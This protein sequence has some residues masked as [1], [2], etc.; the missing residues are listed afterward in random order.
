MS[1]DTSHSAWVYKTEAGLVQ[2]SPNSIVWPLLGSICFTRLK[3]PLCLTE[4]TENLIS[5]CKTLESWWNHRWNLMPDMI[6]LQHLWCRGDRD[7]H[8][9]T[10]VLYSQA[11]KSRGNYRQEALNPW[12][13][14]TDSKWSTSLV[15]LTSGSS[16]LFFFFFF[17]T[18]KEAL[19]K[20]WGEGNRSLWGCHVCESGLNV[21]KLPVFPKLI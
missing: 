6:K 21:A 1:R 4:V 9:W 7:I 2:Q 8:R 5:M 14:R 19:S 12:V 11:H 18:T 17:P 13:T 3:V 16:S 10:F 15:Y 20:F